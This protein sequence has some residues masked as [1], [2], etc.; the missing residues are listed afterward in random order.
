MFVDDEHTVVGHRTRKSRDDVLPLVEGLVVEHAQQEH[1]IERTAERIAR[2]I[3]LLNANPI[4]EAM[5]RNQC[6]CRRQTFSEVEHGGMKIWKTL[7]EAN[8]MQSVAS[9]D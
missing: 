6:R 7:T 3:T 2:G 8:R 4:G 1:H 5:F 9:A